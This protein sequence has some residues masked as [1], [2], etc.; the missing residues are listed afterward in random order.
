MATATDCKQW[1]YSLSSSICCA[2][3]SHLIYITIVCIAATLVVDTSYADDSARKYFLISS[4]SLGG[5]Y[6]EAGNILAESL[7]KI[8]SERYAFKVITSNGSI[9][10]IK[11]LKDRFSDFAI[12]QRDVFIRN[13]YGDGDKIKN[14]SIITPLFKE[15]F[16][17]YTHQNSHISFTELKELINS[18][19]AAIKIGLTSLDGAS[20]KTFSE[21]ASLLGL[22]TDN[23]KFVVGNYNE[24]SNKYFS[25]EIDFV[26]TFSLPIKDFS[27][28]HEVYF[29]D[30]DIRLL[31]SRMRYLT[32]ARLD[33]KKHQ[34]LGVWALFIGLNSSI[35]QVGEDAIIEHISP[36]ALKDSP[37]EYQINNTFHEFK[38]NS[39]LY[40]RYLKGLPVIASFQKAINR[41]DSRTA[42]HIVVLLGMLIIFALTASWLNRYSQ[43]HR[44]YIWIRYK[45]IFVGFLVIACIYLLCMEWLIFSEKEFFRENGIKSSILDITR[46]DLHLWNLVRVFA[47]NDGGIFPIS[48]TGKLAT[49]LSMY[50]IW[51]GS[52]SIAAVEFIMHKLVAKRREGLMK[53]TYEDHTIIAG[54]NDNTPKL[55]EE[56]LYASNEYHHKK[57]RIVCVVP[58][59][60]SI[61]E[62]HK[63]ISDLEHRKE[64]V[65]VKGYIRHKDILA[66]CNA[67]HAKIIILLAEETG[68]HADEKTLMRALGIRKFCCEGMRNNKDSAC[69]MDHI[70]DATP[71]SAGLF[72][73]ESETNPVYIIAEINTEEF[74]SDLRDAGVNGII[75]KNKISDSLLI[76]SILNPGVSKLINNILTFSRDTNEFYT[77][78][79]LDPNN[80]HLRNHTFDELLVPLRKQNILLIAI[81]VVYRDQAGNEIVDE[82]EVSRLLKSEGLYRQII[83]NPITDAETNRKTDFDD[84]LITLAVSAD[85]LNAGLKEVAFF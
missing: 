37:I 42:I 11:R 47:N 10:N 38:Y 79:L 39:T 4:G 76:Q 58:D 3:Y 53:I 35:N 59:P 19:P 85:K 63:Y 60:K 18:S 46:T 14:V 26:L 64:L 62:R 5:N 84:Q 54:W 61:L 20:Y 28:A 82:N 74:I 12:V 9:E 16:L 24:L 56:L 69:S 75:N 21:I 36:P 2:I 31:T 15:K 51:I 78:D 17:I 80:S 71:G 68:V 7:N 72:K 8:S 57:V 22:N 83:T 44:K 66:Q 29:N 23:V 81:K 30:A 67:C 34:T 41:Y 45:H 50:V 40:N 65:L 73:T 55:I 43:E 32:T 13:Y 49:T 27:K 6:N 52:L 33:K 25:G 70:P 48:V 1:A 77:V